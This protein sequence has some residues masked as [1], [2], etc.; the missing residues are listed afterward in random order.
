MSLIATERTNAL[1]GSLR[2]DAEFH[3][4]HFREAREVLAKHPTV[5]LGRVASTIKKGIFDIKASTYVDEGVP[6][7]RISNLREGL[8]E[9]NGMAHIPSEVDAE[10]RTTHF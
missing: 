8:I 6:F 4:P 7:I 10:H 5:P 3:Q 2:L 1:P 9:T